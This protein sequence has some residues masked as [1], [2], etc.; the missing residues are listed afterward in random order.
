MQ[1]PIYAD[2]KLKIGIYCKKYFFY[3]FRDGGIPRP[4]GRKAGQSPDGFVEYTP[5]LCGAGDLF[6]KKRLT[7]ERSISG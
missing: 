4:L 3:S 2:P 5:P 7:H 1:I 6:L